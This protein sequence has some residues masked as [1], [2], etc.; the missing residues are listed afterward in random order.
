MLCL[1]VYSL[2]VQFLLIP[3]AVFTLERTSQANLFLHR[4]KVQGKQTNKQ[5]NK[6]RLGIDLRCAGVT[7]WGQ[8]I[9]HGASRVC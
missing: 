5:T 4:E 6:K 2:P 7:P 3:P 9:S 8:G 1:L